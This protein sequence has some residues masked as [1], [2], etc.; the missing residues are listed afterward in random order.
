M[1]FRCATACLATILLAGCGQM[2]GARALPP[3]PRGV[4]TQVAEDSYDV[5][6]NT[7]EGIPIS[8]M[9]AGRAALGRYR[10]LH[11]WNLRYR[12]N[13]RQ[14]RNACEM[15]NVTIELE[16]RIMVPRWTGRET[17]DSTVVALW[18]TY[19]TNL[20][21]HEYTHR[22]YSYR[23]ARDISRSL[24]D[25]VAG[26]CAGMRTLANST[27]QRI[28]DQYGRLDEEFDEE[29]RGTI[30]WPPSECGEIGA[31]AAVSVCRSPDRHGSSATPSGCRSRH[32]D[33]PPGAPPLLHGD[34]T[35]APR[36]AP[37]R[38]RKTPTP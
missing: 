17:A 8:L 26:S 12:Y 22:E 37:R 15:T 24:Y 16:S 2:M 38:L 27:A 18:D 20:R 21:G 29:S 30:T 3:L 35:Q 11:T 7:V 10:G 28:I 34:A 1:F 33:A 14:V 19:I 25:L 4:T 5:A 23:A 32:S 9:T 13:Y 31:W 6:G 36:T